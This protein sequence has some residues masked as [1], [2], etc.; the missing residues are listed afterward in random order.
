MKKTYCDKCG[1]EIK[2]NNYSMIGKTCRFVRIEKFVSDI[3]DYCDYCT[4]YMTVSISSI[5]DKKVDI[6]EDE[7]D[8]VLSAPDIGMI[9]KFI[10]VFDLDVGEHIKL[11]KIAKE[12]RSRKS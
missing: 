8:I 7:D 9:S 12:A 3:G 11:A 4:T 6:K 5:F 10:N 2:D 1:D